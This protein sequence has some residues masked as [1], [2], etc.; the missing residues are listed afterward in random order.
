MFS[1]SFRLTIHNYEFLIMNYLK[2]FTADSN[3]LMS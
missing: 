1:V 2:Y 3:I